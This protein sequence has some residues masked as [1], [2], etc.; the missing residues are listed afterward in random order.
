MASQKYDD[1]DDKV[2]HYQKEYSNERTRGRGETSQQGKFTTEKGSSSHEHVY[3]ERNNSTGT[4]RE[5]GHG[6][7]YNSNSSSDSESSS[8]SSGK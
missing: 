4:T 3:A 8:S 6:K 1:G 7:N 5:G 2:V